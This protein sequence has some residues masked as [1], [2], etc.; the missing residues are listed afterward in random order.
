ME[1][2][3][4][5]KRL[6]SSNSKDELLDLLSIYEKFPIS[7]K[8]KIK[9]LL[10][11]EENCDWYIDF[12]SN[13]KEEL[14]KKKKISAFLLA[15]KT[16]GIPYDRKRVKKIIETEK[17]LEQLRYKIYE[18]INETYND[19][20]DEECAKRIAEKASK[21]NR[22]IVCGRFSRAFYI[23]ALLLAN[24][25]LIACE[26]FKENLNKLNEKIKQLKFFP[27]YL[28]TEIN[29]LDY[30][31]KEK[32]TAKAQ[33]LSS[34][35][36]LEKDLIDYELKL[37][38]NFNEGKIE[39]KIYEN[40]RKVI[41]SIR[42]EI[43]E[44]K[45]KIE[46]EKGRPPIYMVFF[47]RIFPIDAIF[48][49]L[50]NELM[51]PFFGEDPH[52]DELLSEG[53]ENIYVTPGMK[54]WL[55]V[56]DDW[57]EALPAYAS[58]EI[59]PENGSYKF[60]PYVQ[61]NILEEMYRAN[62]D[63]WAEN[64][65]DVM[66]TEHLQLAREFI[67]D[68]FKIKYKNE[69]ELIKK[70]G[71]FKEEVSMV[72]ALI[73]KTYENLIENI[74]R[75]CEKENILRFDGLKKI[76]EERK[77]IISE[78]PVEIK[79]KESFK[80]ILQNLIKKYNL[81]EKVKE[82]LENFHR[83]RR[84]LPSVHVLTT[85]GPG[86]TEF[87]VK[88]WLE[89]GMLLYN[90]IKKNNL[91]GKVEEKRKIW[92]ENI[93]KVGEKIVK[94]NNLESEVYKLDE[95]NFKEG[96]VKI[97]FAYPDIGKE[98]AK[99]CILLIN[100]GQNFNKDN[101]VAKE[102]NEIIKEL[103]PEIKEKLGT[104]KLTEEE[105]E[106]LKNL[107]QELVKKYNLEKNVS[108]FLKDY[109]HPVYSKV[110]AQRQVITEEGLL[111]ELNKPIY[112]YE[113]KGAYKKYN[114]LYTPSR[115]DLGA[116]EVYSVRDIPKWVGGIDNYS[117]L[118]GKSLYS[119]YN[120]AGPTVVPSTR[121]AEFLKVGE[122]FFS[123][124]G[125]F[126]LSLTAGINL[127]V[128][129]FGEFEFFRNQWNM[130]GDRIVLPSGE[131][132]GGFCV[133]K[134]FS[135]LYAIII[136]AVDK[137]TSSKILNSFGIPEKLHE[138]VISDLR[139]V[140]AWRLDF[141]LEIDWEGKAL[142]YLY[143]KY[144]EYFKIYGEPVYLSRLP[145][146][147][148]TLEKMGIVI[149]E[150]EEERINEFKLTYWVNKKA[151]G[152]E[153]INRIGPFRKVKLIYDLIKR[154]REKNKYIVPDDAL[155]G[156]M[157]VSYKESEVEDGRL[158]P[159]SDVRFSAGCRKLEIYSLVAEK[160]ILL[161]IDPEGREI[162]KEIFKNFVPPADIRI[163]GRCTGSDI[164]NH[165]PNSG[166]EEIKNEVLEYLYKIGLDEN[167]I[168]TNCIVYGGDIKKWVGIRERSV[169]EINKIYNDLKGKIHLLVIDKRGPFSSYKIA[170]RG[171]DFV[172][173]G[174]PD[175]ELLQLIDNLPEFIYLIKK[176]RPFSAL[177][178]AD[179]T[180]GAR[181]PSFAY[182]YPNCRRKVKELFAIEEKA[183]YGCLGIGKETIDEWR[184]EMEIERSLS[185]ELLD[186][187]LN[188]SKT[189]FL[190]SMK[191]IRNYIIKE[192]KVDQAILEE[193]QAKRIN[194]WNL[195]DKVYTETFLHLS[196]ENNYE[197]FDFGKWLIFGG[198]FLLNGKYTKNEVENLRSEF[199]R[200]LKK[201]LKEERKPYSKKE[202]DFIIEKYFRPIYIPELKTKYEEISTG[203]AGSLKAAEIQTQA[204]ARWQE[205]KREYEKIKNLQK[206]KEN[207]K[208]FDFTSLK[209]LALE[210]IYN[211]AKEI[212]G[213]PQR[214]IPPEVFGKFLAI[215]KVYIEK[216]IYETKEIQE[217]EKLLNEIENFFNSS[218]I[219]EENY[220]NFATLISNLPKYK[221]NDLKFYEK[222]CMA[223]ELLDISF[224]L[225]L[226]SNCY[227]ENE[228]N[229]AIAKFLDR[230]VNSHIFDYL[231]YH[232]HRERS[233]YFE[234]LSRD[235]KFKFAF[236]FHKFLY[237]HLRYLVCEKTDLKYYSEEYKEL[238]IGN[239]LEKKKAI[240]I[241]GETEEEIFWFHYARIRDA[242]VLKYEGFGYPEI[243]TDVEIEDIKANE[244][245][246][247]VIVYP[248]GNTTVPVALQQGPKFAQNKINL[249]LTAFPEV[250]EIND[251]KILQIK[252]G[253]IYLSEDE[254]N[255]IREKYQK[256]VQLKSDF[257]FLSF[258]NPVTAHAIFFHFTHPLRPYIDHFKI[259]IIQ[260]L[261]WEAATHLKCELP[262]MLAGSGVKVPEQ[263]NWYMKDTE[264][265][266]DKAK[267]K[268]REKIKNLAKK[269]DT[270]IVKC[271]KESGGRKS[272]ILPVREN[273]KYLEEN[274]D[275]LTDLVY[276]I[277]LTDNAVIQEVIKSRVRQLY[278]REFLENVVERFAK[279]GIPVLI[280]REPQT[281]LYS[282]F[283][284][285]VVLGKEGYKIS[286]HI[287]VISTRGIANVGQGGLLYE[288]TDDIIHPK[289]R[290][291]LREQITKAVYKSL[292]YQQ[293]YLEKNWKFVI[294]EYLKIHPEFKEKVKYD[295]IFTDLTG[296]PITGIPYEMGDYMPVFLVDEFENLRYIYDEKEGKLLP[297][298]DE[299]G[300]PT[301]IKIY[302][303]DGK[304]I[305][306]IDK[307]KKSVLIPYFDENGNP[308]KIYDEDGKEIPP[309][310]ICKIEPN[311]GAG[312]W[313][314]H[315]DRLPPERKGE[316]VFIIFS[317][318]A[319]R[320]KIYKEKIEKLIGN[321]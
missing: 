272:M 192:N 78:I 139:K 280:D 125:V 226:V 117:A 137:E 158:I 191:K 105:A 250:K 248:Y 219:N 92:K 43:L 82:Y 204:L 206:R 288:Y 109:L 87:N 89:E 31:L 298:Y 220:I 211:K 214:M 293:K 294:E 22:R 80:K 176:D 108:T 306:R 283:R 21:E 149:P 210:E 160:H 42:K 188:E 15:R 258:K 183:V 53:G 181:R 284:Q 111:E 292:E 261:I 37:I 196:K 134:E 279:I 251:Y 252:E 136:S 266:K 56:C 103:P 182:G 147:A 216:L 143:S 150:G 116:K 61:R 168:K 127:D 237:S 244:R 141:Q 20:F 110:N 205:R 170:V 319:E 290:K 305:P 135:L 246:N 164:L 166:L 161:D 55:K 98:V 207:Y 240:G 278:T 138:I 28:Y 35:K 316:G 97:L 314:P 296:F 4:F 213:E 194:N 84:N 224:L 263:I 218:E 36:K 69:D 11:K 90:F 175:P 300:R 62:A 30:L 25:R 119:L 309:L 124:G 151:Q 13:E 277:S 100:E 29:E 17:D 171:V 291:I 153:E 267:E 195:K 79:N 236:K 209:N 75:I 86:E 289:Y 259:P 40:D 132:Y 10:L 299:K 34:L 254:L 228:F 163:V 255:H 39:N 177:V 312:L 123:R 126:Y 239:I 113:A 180:S 179:G 8:E 73:E 304:E 253:M 184:K 58:Y 287:T 301:D 317:C 307:N 81:E 142:S 102:P 14:I 185:K 12:L 238:Y 41:D 145:Q 215:S 173:L 265:F 197:Y 88:N 47:Q 107:R 273:G 152:L 144:P 174:I 154:A 130:R 131:T 186:S 60:K 172:D 52:I 27:S 59:I 295:E 262:K 269:Y 178:F 148:L 76:I 247:L 318:L 140:L 297:L 235:L 232:Y 114:L 257:V 112:R 268:I 222:V 242:V 193:Q 217:K 321:L 2:R 198:I 96:I 67:A 311:P 121:I 63:S 71:K 320:G 285:I 223:L 120:I 264:K 23:D 18:A 64:I 202:I 245:V 19:T 16:F 128:L 26:K 315:N 274:I 66:L 169:E 241:K 72:A 5:V 256:I 93:I 156:V 189:S 57:I 104:N 129:R 6:L 167:L 199:E 159:V 221:E 9:N 208:N 310:I 74:G 282:Y 302:D 44:F 118:S 1:E 313:R 200:K 243:Y 122:N 201:I 203:L 32:E 308:R 229:T 230:T 85:L 50:L 49:G 77:D 99:L 91:S 7:K 51:D 94:E 231:P 260:P 249:F 95:K 270:I 48:M 106:K 187:V 233:P 146:I 275:K 162:I 3:K 45:R 54:N 133:P 70:L 68:L 234:K 303:E 38:Q 46:K 227:T 281:P 115:V 276:E 65:N 24:S 190:E 101:F 33:I 225:E 155:I 212:L 165:V 157:D 271:E 286:H 83:K